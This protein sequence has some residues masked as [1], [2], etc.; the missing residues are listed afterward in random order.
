MKSANFCVFV[1]N[2]MILLSSCT[3][4]QTYDYEYYGLNCPVKSVKVITYEAESKFGEI[5]KGDLEWHG[6][7]LA[8]FSDVGNLESISNYDD[9]GELIS[10]DKYKYDEDNK[11][12][13]ISSYDNNGDLI[14][15]IMYTYNED[16]IES[17]TQ[18]SYWNDKEE[19]RE[20]KH[21][22]H[23]EQLVETMII[24]NG[25]LS[26]I[27]KY[28]SNSK[29]NSKWITY[30]KNGKEISRGD[31]A[32]NEY[33]QMVSRNE[34]ELHIIVEW[35]D[36]KLPTF[37]KN[38]HLSNNTI[39]SWYRTGEENTYY[40]EYEYDKKGNWIKQVVYEGEIKTPL[41]ISERV[42]QY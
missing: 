26:T 17:F 24:E 13:V 37:L 40:V 6:H 16:L 25:E 22:W 21:K 33:G 42:I 39:I 3:N 27:I 11:V 20:Y 29:N 12:T 38:A 9:D 10:V 1:I 36:K 2:F 30:D 35:N 15:Q 4:K 23:G 32:Y 5:V 31:E 19:I 8:I 18:K 7:Y 14:D 34:G 41:T 28:T